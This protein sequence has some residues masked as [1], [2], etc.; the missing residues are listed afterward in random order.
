MSESPFREHRYRPEEVRAV[1]RRALSRDA[2]R[3]SGRALTRDELTAILSDLGVSQSAA[4]QA[5]D[6]PDSSAVDS[7]SDPDDWLGGPKR[8][9]YEEEVDGELA[10]DR[11]E[12]AVEVI[13]EMM[14]EPGRVESLGRTVT[15]APT[16]VANNQQ[17]RLSVKLRVRDGRTRIRVDEDLSPLRLG[18]WLGFGI[19]GGLGLGILGI[20]AGKVAHSVALGGLVWLVITAACLFAAWLVTRW[21]SG[22]RKR[23]LRRLFD[24]VREEVIRGAAVRP[25]FAAPASPGEEA[26]AEEAASEEAHAEEAHAAEEAAAAEKRP[27]RRKQ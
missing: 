26:E 25:R 21:V 22:R 1:I 20:P 18:A 23:D 16:P 9:V 27:R 4:E 14:G 10:D 8:I 6:Q 11:R 17:R 2:E 7:G 24:K 12:D 3:G 19:G 5:L 15:W 13:R